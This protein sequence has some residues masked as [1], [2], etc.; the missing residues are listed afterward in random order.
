[1]LGVAITISDVP[2]E[3]GNYKNGKGEGFKQNYAE[4]YK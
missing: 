3:S 1:V 2:D 4:D